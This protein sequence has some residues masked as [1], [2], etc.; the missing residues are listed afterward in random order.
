MP[1]VSLVEC[2]S[3]DQVDKAV[4]KAVDLLGGMKK[5]VKKG[6]KVLLKMNLLAGKKP[7]EQTITHPS[8]IKAVAELVKKEGA[9]P[10]VG[11]NPG[12]PAKF[13]KEAEKAGILDFFKKNK[14]KVADLSEGEFVQ[15]K[16]AKFC[17]SFYLSKRLKEFDVIINMPKLKTHGLNT[18][19]LAVK[20]LYG[21][22]PGMTKVQMHLRFQN[23]DLFAE[24]LVDLHDYV[25][26][27]LNILDGVIGMEGQGP[28]AGTAR[29]FNLIAASDN[30]FSMDCVITK[31]MGLRQEDIPSIRIALKHGIKES[32]IRNVK[33]VGENINN[34]VITDLKT[35]VSNFV[36]IPGFVKKGL[37]GLFVPKPYLIKKKC[38]KCATCFRVCPA[39]AIKMIPYPTYD[40][41]K[42]IKCYC[43]HEMC[44][45][46]AIEIRYAKPVEIAVKIKKK[47]MG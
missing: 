33:V 15:K 42:C 37:E 38:T 46:H 22:I 23:K 30:A 27:N 31:I 5:F 7:E 44:P 40:Y 34:L 1:T 29:N 45:E 28:M 6:D 8:V 4:E 16:S 25:K 39:K 24:M 21:C 26:P 36:W 19:T 9:I 32:D 18:L 17:K 47:I 43:C 14:I 10:Y 3:Y 13:E 20:N 12:G 41:K 35:P 11:D 2:K